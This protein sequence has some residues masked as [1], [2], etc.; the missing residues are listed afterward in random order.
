MT[1]GSVYIADAFEHPTR[2]APDTSTME[3]HAEVAKGALADAGL[4]H[5]AVDGYLT[6]GGPRMEA[7]AMA[8]YLGL[9][10]DYAD[11]TD[12]GGSSYVAHVGH[13]A[14]AIRDG[15][16]DVALITLAGRP[17]SAGQATGTGTRE[18]SGAGFL[19]TDL[20][21]NEPHPVR[22]G[23]ASAHARVRHDERTAG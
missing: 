6:A 2:E 12:Y 3:L 19:R 14:G 13:A 21:G 16:C 4:P 17:R 10:I 1:Q 20:R 11:T 7:L 9:S 15:R 8:D 18:Q 5:E 22:H 23:R